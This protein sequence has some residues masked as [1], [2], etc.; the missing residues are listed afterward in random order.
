MYTEMYMGIGR[1]SSQ[2]S[3]T[4]LAYRPSYA[5]LSSTQTGLNKQLFIC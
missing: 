4:E 3:T 1:L 5:M 2:L